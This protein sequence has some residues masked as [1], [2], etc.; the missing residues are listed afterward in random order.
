MSCYE[1]VLAFPFMEAVNAFDFPFCCP[2][3]T[4]HVAGRYF[5]YWKDRNIARCY[6]GSCS[7]GSWTIIDMIMHYHNVDFSEALKKACETL[8]I[9]YRA[10]SRMIE[11]SDSL[12]IKKEIAG[13]YRAV[14][15]KKIESV[16]APKSDWRHDRF[17][18]AASLYFRDEHLLIA[19]QF[20]D[21][22]GR[23]VPA[24]PHLICQTAEN[25]EK[26]NLEDNEYGAWVCINP[27]SGNSEVV[28]RVGKKLSFSRK[29]Q[30]GSNDIS[31]FSYL[32]VESD[33]MSIDEQYSWLKASRLPIITLT[34]SGG[35]SLHAIVLIDAQS[36][37]EYTRKCHDV[38]TVLQA[39]GFSEDPGNANAN[40]YTRLPGTLRGDNPQYMIDVSS[41]EK[42]SNIDEW[43][44]Y[45][46]IKPAEV[47]TTLYNHIDIWNMSE[48]RAGLLPL[49]GDLK[50]YNQSTFILPFNDLKTGELSG[51]YMASKGHSQ[52]IGTETYYPCIYAS[53]QSNLLCIC[54]DIDK[55]QQY[56]SQFGEATYYLAYEAEC[57]E[58]WPIP[59][60]IYD[61]IFIITGGNQDY[62]NAAHYHK[63][64]Y[65]NKKMEI[66]Q[67]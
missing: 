54:P 17:R 60:G 6:G 7:R 67:K 40:R 61:Q 44:D 12:K 21:S 57:L 24:E 52:I 28:E 58:I 46:T 26:L 22:A 10:A 15:C 42:F 23:P 31:R 51:V 14:S 66:I 18:F 39:S 19:N 9:R 53:S 29:T 64:K 30:K 35:K 63:Q 5:R 8:H 3:N 27:V 20:Y 32:L 62:L 45:M 36:E 56:M 11:R 34:H 38:Y 16:P 41:W 48:T 47:I 37:E 1:E 59:N 25:I 13:E 4:S 65:N 49:S 50:V 55:I 43:L 2:E 33:T